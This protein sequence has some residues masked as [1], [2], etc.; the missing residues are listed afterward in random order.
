MSRL[1][2]ITK[3]FAEA[4]QTGSTPDLSPED[5]SWCAEWERWDLVAAAGYDPEELREQYAVAS[6]TD[7]F[8]TGGVP[9]VGSDREM[10]IGKGGRVETVDPD[11][12]D[13]PED[14]ETSG[15]DLP[16]D[17]NDWRVPEL[18]EECLRRQLP[19]DGNKADLVTRLEE[20]DKTADD[21]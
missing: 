12:D 18:R 16:D 3:K 21:R 13:E 2:F 10:R 4:E 19:G 11:T 7:R 15:D 5:L 20:D 17:Y 14:A 6:E 8:N 1:G 9:R